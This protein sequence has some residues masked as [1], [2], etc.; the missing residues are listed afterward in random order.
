MER[1]ISR[2]IGCESSLAPSF[3]NSPPKL[4]NPT[5]FDGSICCS[6]FRTVFSGISEKQK[7]LF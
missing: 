4:S 7:K 2:A 6:N 1:F 5:A 3:K